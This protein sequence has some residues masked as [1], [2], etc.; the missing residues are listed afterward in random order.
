MTLLTPDDH[1]TAETWAAKSTGGPSTAPKHWQPKR[2]KKKK[3][4]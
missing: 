4:Q 3:I 2:I 1:L